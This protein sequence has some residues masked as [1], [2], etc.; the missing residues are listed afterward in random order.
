MVTATLRIKQNN[1]HILEIYIA[2][3]TDVTDMLEMTINYCR[4]L[5]EISL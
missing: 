4:Y 1:L 3:Q 2:S 5:A